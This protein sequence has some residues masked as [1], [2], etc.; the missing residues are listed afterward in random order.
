MVKGQKIYVF[1]MLSGVLLFNSC[2]KEQF[3]L[4]KLSDEIEVY[5][6][7][8]APLVYGSLTM[9]DLVAEF[10]STGTIGEFEDRLL[11]LA[12]SDTLYEVRLDT[13][14]VL[15]DGFYTQI[16]IDT[17]I[18]DDPVFIGSNVGDTT[19]FIKSK[20]FG[21]TTEGDNRMDSIYFKGGDLLTEV[22]STF[23]HAGYLTISSPYIRDRDGNPY[24]YQVNISDAGGNYS[25]SE[26][27]S[28]DGYFMKT[29]QQGDSSIFRMDY[30]FALIN[31]GNPVL[32]W[33]TC[34]IKSSFLDMG[35]YELYGFVDPNEVVMERGVLDIP[36]YPDFPELV[37]LKVADPRINIFTENSMGIP[38]Q[39]TLD[40]IIGTAD[41][42]ATETLSIV[43]GHPFIIPAPDIDMVGE[44]AYGDFYINNQTSNIKDLFN[45]APRTLS[46]RLSG[47]AGSQHQEHFL[48][49]TSRFMAELE[50][51]LPLDLAFT[52]YSLSGTLEFTIAEDGIDTSKVKEVVIKL[53]TVNTL[54]LDLGLQVYM[55]DSSNMI[56]D[57]LFSGEPVFISA[58][59]VD[60]EGKLELA[61]KDSHSVDFPAEKLETLKNVD[62]LYVKARMVTAESG[63][64][65]VK[66]YS[67]YSLDFEISFYAA[68]RINT[69]E[70]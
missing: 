9:S 40:S 44:T 68:F 41:N 18:S 21:F 15:V 61:S 38:F 63:I 48:L 23:R 56:L 59:E 8:V 17:E 55:L 33:N 22:E 12:Y 27:E 66:F 2:Q 39:L 46:Y 65:F 43:Q 14:D 60:N 54:P 36:I 3:Q 70:L 10:D 6:D 26:S 20:Y 28:L 4:D 30:D 29:D 45:I 42:G 64:P 69:R 57:S 13:V 34:E 47:S 50:F 7:L 51:L 52:K 62:Y 1:L 24:S 67:D 35:F 32:P 37:Q 53:S 58:S 25:W 19:H 49:D 31:S 11:Y 5:T 16:Y